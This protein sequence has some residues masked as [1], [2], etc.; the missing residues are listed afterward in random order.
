MIHAF[1]LT[2][3]YKKMKN[4]SGCMS[5][6][7]PFL[8]LYDWESIEYPT[9]ISNNDYTLF[10]KRNLEIALTAR[11]GVKYVLTNIRQSNS[12][13]YLKN[14][15]NEKKVV[16]LLIQECISIEEE[17]SKTKSVTT[18]FYDIKK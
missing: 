10:E 2:Q 15:L 12:H 1:A 6:I 16:F 3:H 17:L 7:K 14:I 5:N 9:V 4:Y 8:D 11:I 18:N 13:M